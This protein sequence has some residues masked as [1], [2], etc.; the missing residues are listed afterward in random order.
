MRT[1]ALTSRSPVRL[2]S[3]E[4]KPARTGAS[5]GQKNRYL[6]DLVLVD[7]I[8]VMPEIILPAVGSGPTVPYL[9]A[10]WSP[11]STRRPSSPSPSLMAA[12]RPETA[13]PRVYSAW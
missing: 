1:I 3:G 4:L 8:G 9:P 11:T 12:L 7:E 6:L 5:N 13:T 2:C 10:T